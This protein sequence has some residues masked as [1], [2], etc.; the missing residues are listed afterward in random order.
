[1]DISRVAVVGAGINGA[2]HCHDFRARRLVRRNPAGVKDMPEGVRVAGDLAPT[3]DL[4]IE[5]I[6]ELRDLKP[7]LFHRMDALYG[8]VAALRRKNADKL[9]RILEIANE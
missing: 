1:M 2:R 4:V 3:A 6:P 7:D 5:P 9:R 8:D